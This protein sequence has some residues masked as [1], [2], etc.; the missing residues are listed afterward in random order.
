[1]NNIFLKLA[2]GAVR[3]LA[4]SILADDLLWATDSTTTTKVE[5][6]LAQGNPAYKA[7]PCMFVRVA[8]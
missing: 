2:I 8:P 6:I 7:L 4:D 5:A 3:S 1:M